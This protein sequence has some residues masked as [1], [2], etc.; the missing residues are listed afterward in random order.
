[1]VYASESRALA[2]VEVL[3]HV[4]LERVP[5]DLFIGELY[6]PARAK[7]EQVDVADLPRNWRDYPAPPALAV[8]GSEWIRSLRS[9]VLRVP[10]ADVDR[11]FNILLNPLHPQIK[12]VRVSSY[13]PFIFDQRLVAKRV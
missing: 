2:A 13:E 6:I 1:M 8:I 12:Q 10:S 3:V 4:S 9:L 5:Q 11:E 7:V